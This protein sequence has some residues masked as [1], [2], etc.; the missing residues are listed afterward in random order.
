[1]N[2]AE[3]LDYIHGTLKFGVKL[4]LENITAL[5]SLMG[6]PHKSLKFIHVAGT[7]GKGST[8]AFISSILMESGYKTGIYTS[9]YLER[10]TE[11]IKIGI[12]E[13][14]DTDVARITYFVKEKVDEL[15]RNGG[16]HPTEFEI[17][18][19]V[20]FQYFFENNCD[21][22]VLE[23]GLGGRFDSTNVIDCPLAA[24][25]TTI[26]YDHM[27]ILGDTL[28]KIAY[29]KA[30][31][32]KENTDVVLYPQSDEALKVFEEVCNDKNSRLNKILVSDFDILESSIWGSTFFHKKYG[33]FEIHIPGEH[34]A[35]NAVTALEAVNILKE[36]GFD[37]ICETAVDRG[38]K[39]A[40]WPGRLEV[41]CKDPVFLIDGAHN[42]EG[43]LTL[44]KNLK[45]YF[46]GKRIIIIVGVLKDKDYKA[47]IEPLVPIASEFIAVKPQSNRG[48][49]AQE[50]AIILR[51][52]C[53]EVS[54]S[55]RIEDAIRYSMKK[56]SKSGIICAYG[57]L[58]YIGEVRKFFNV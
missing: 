53:N 24:V 17:V 55:D 40:V 21:V 38:L 29:E 16:N 51:S 15:I 7:N 49:E 2:Y 13:I 36:K 10:F 4:G 11:R 43:A 19:A 3:A 18:T 1:M 39:K 42:R 41:V 58:Y 52:Y 26:S 32:I 45:E 9:P 20:A 37:R 31:I 50:L 47:I 44:A 34:Q 6:D 25:I 23:V 48:M 28:E 5:L 54:V 46:P 12:E 35:V 14:S 57:S 22:V 56:V 27:N 8:V 33:R 30:G